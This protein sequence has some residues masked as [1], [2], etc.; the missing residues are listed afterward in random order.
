[1]RKAVI[2]QTSSG[3]R[4][5]CEKKKAKSLQATASYGGYRADKPAILFIYEK[6]IDISTITGERFTQRKVGEKTKTLICGQSLGRVPDKGV[7]LNLYE[8]NS[9]ISGIQASN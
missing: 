7:I 2:Y 9:D 1:M 3:R 4:F 8:T 5:S 6:Y